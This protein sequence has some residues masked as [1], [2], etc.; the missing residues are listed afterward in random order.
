MPTTLHGKDSLHYEEKGIGQSLIFI[1]G[2]GLDLS[3]WEEQV[4]DLSK[5]FRVITY[6]MVGHGGSEHPPGPYSLSQF[7]EQLAE[8]MNHL[9][10]ERS[11]IIG[12]SM[13]DGR[14]GICIKISG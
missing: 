7:V 2:V 4:E 13:G 12:F 8:L 9:R 3:M 10:I 5:H 11:H 6:D 14:S 1:H